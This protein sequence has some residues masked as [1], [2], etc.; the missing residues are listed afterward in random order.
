MSQLITISWRDIPSLVIA[1]SGRKKTKVQLSERFQKAIDRAAMKAGR[2]GS[3]AYLHDWQRSYEKCAG[4]LEAVAITAA[5]QLEKSYSDEKLER[6]VR[7][8][9]VE[10]ESA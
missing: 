7:S 10:D 9:G 1:K 2:Q 5:E 8:G 6:L 3:E 4:E